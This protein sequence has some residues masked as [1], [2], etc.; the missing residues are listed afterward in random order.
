MSV[1][2]MLTIP[3]IMAVAVA[4]MTFAVPS[5]AAKYPPTT[6]PRGLHAIRVNG[7][8]RVGATHWLTITGT[9]FHGAITITSN[10]PGLTA[11]V[12]HDN[13]HSLVVKVTIAAGEPKGWHVFT[14]HD[15]G[16]TTEVRF[17][18]K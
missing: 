15:G 4:T 9:G 18:V 11:T 10:E 5:G 12:M 8:P 7:F 14:I 1:R 16:K 2:R 13:G 6:L 3:T 17:L